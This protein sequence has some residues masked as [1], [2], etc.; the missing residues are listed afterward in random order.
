MPQSQMS[1]ETYS[2]FFRVYENGLC[3]VVDNTVKVN[4]NDMLYL[5]AEWLFCLQL[6]F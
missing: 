1:Y 4:G 2:Q 3:L 6:S 5:L